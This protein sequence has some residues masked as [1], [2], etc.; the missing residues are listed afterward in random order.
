MAEIIN[1]TDCVVISRHVVVEPEFLSQQLLRHRILEK[2]RFIAEHECSKDTG[3]II[4]VHGIR[5]IRDN[6]VSN[7]TSN[8]IF[9]VEVDIERLKP[10]IGN[11]YKG[12][13]TVV[14]CKGVFINVMERLRIFVPLDN[15]GY[16]FN[17]TKSQFTSNST[18]RT[19][20]VGDLIT[21]S[22]I[23]IKYVDKK[24]NCIATL[25]D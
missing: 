2:I 13:V 5:R 7:A 24:F 4:D 18:K 9:D 1:K 19:I 14:F 23:G 25:S 20:S 16:T 15:N 12:I 21:V 8:I 10:E 6:Y 11:R 17:K 22:I 3:Y